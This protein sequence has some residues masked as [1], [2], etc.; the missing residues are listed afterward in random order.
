MAVVSFI[1]GESISRGDAVFITDGGTVV[2]AIS[3]FTGYADV[4]GIALNDAEFGQGI[5]VNIDDTVNIPGA[6]FTPGDILYLSPTN[7]GAI[8]NYQGFQSEFDAAQISGAYL[9]KIGTALDSSLLKIE[10]K[11]PYL[12]GPGP[13]PGPLPVR[14]TILLESSNPGYVEFDVLDENGDP[15]LLENAVAP[16][17]P[18]PSGINFILVE[19][20]SGTTEFFLLDELNN[21]VLLEET[22]PP[23]PIS[24]GYILVEGSGSTDADAILSEGGDP[25]LVELASL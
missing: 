15:I 5:Y 4:V 2:R 22:L 9:S 21:P 25:I 1:A 13:V 18:P 7:S 16:L 6:S 24:S 3:R 20:S 11:L 17:P 12:F 23:P 10:T 8:V 19:T 14:F